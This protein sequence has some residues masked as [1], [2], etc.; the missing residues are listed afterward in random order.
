MADCRRRGRQRHRLAARGPRLRA[1]FELQ[2]MPRLPPIRHCAGSRGSHRDRA[3]KPKNAASGPRFPAIRAFARLRPQGL[4]TARASCP[5]QRWKPKYSRCRPGATSAAYRAASISS[6][7]EPHIGSTSAPPSAITCGQP[8]RSSTAQASVSFSGA[9]TCSIRQPRRCRLSPDRSMLS[10]A[11]SR[12]RL[13]LMRTSG[14][15]V[16]TD[17]RSPWRVRNWSTTASL[18]RCSA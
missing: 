17:G 3:S 6:V 4:A 14:C 16:S 15:A 12:R 11:R 13:R 8:A 10:V 7:P 1:C 9:A 5:R 2:C 18:T